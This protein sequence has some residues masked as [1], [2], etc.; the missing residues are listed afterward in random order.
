M[1][2]PGGVEELVTEAHDE[3]VLD[4]LLTEI[5]VDTEDLLLL[6]VGLEGFLQLAR[7]VEVLAEGLLDDDPGE[8]VLGVAVALQLI[9]DGDED[10]GGQSHVEDTVL[11][12]LALFDLV[13]MLV[14]VDE[15]VVL[16][17]LAGDVGAHLAEVLKQLLDFFCGHLDVGLDA[18]Q[19]F[20]VV[21]LCPGIS[22]DFDILGEELVAVLKKSRKHMDVNYFFFNRDVRGEGTK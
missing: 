5:V 10:T 19:V 6:P 8:T 11:L 1:A 21:H 7:A 22:D 12:L 9:G 18:L 17:V 2:V 16:V 13:E 15:G 3:D 4:H 14:Q 20:F